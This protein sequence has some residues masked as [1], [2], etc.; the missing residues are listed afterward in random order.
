MQWEL[1]VVLVLAIPVLLFPVAYIWYIDIGGIILA[2]RERREAKAAQK[3][4]ATV[5]GK[6]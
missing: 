4:L 1:I 2:V 5:E 6:F 3:K